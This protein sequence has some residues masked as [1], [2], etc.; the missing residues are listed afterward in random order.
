MKWPPSN[1][2][3]EKFYYCWYTLRIRSTPPDR[4]DGPTP[5][6]KKSWEYRPNSPW[7]IPI[8]PVKY[9]QNRGC[10]MG[11]VSLQECIWILSG[12]LGGSP[13]FPRPLLW[14]NEHSRRLR[15]VLENHHIFFAD[16]S[17]IFWPYW[18]EKKLSEKPTWSVTGRSVGRSVFWI[19]F[20]K[21]WSVGRSVG[22]F[23]HPRVLRD[24]YDVYW[25][26]AG[27][28]SWVV[29]GSVVGLFDCSV[30]GSGL[31]FFVLLFPWRI[32]LTICI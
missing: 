32:F 25:L 31:L 3:P 18:Q 26:G 16:S 9:H 27:G 23:N 4:I 6:P 14:R 2:N 12:I 7:K 29:S 13:P 10:S 15:L 24:P 21:S 20:P 17:Y 11:Y 19:S 1:I 22:L 28:W 30:L 8:F 5:I